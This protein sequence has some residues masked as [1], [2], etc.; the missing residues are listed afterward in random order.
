MD[1]QRANREGGGGMMTPEGNATGAGTLTTG[2][3]VAIIAALLIA[4]AN[5][6]ISGLRDRED[7]RF[8]NHKQRIDA[9]E[10]K[11]SGLPPAQ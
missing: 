7:E 6:G 2:W 3:K 9:L 8:E 11:T 5:S 4:L 10:N 1:D